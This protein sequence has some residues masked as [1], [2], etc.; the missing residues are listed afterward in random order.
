MNGREAAG[1]AVG[2][3]LR[4]ASV[5]LGG[6]PVLVW[7]AAGTE[8]MVLQ[9]V[10]TPDAAPTVDGDEVSAVLQQWH[11]PIRHGTRWVSCRL[12]DRSAWVIAPLRARPA[13]PP[14]HG[15][16]RRSRERM[17]LELAGLCLGL[18]DAASR[19]PGGD[20]LRELAGLP[21]MIA[22][23]A[24]NPLTAAR[25]GLQLAMSA[26]GGW[27]D[28][29]AE[30]RLELLADL[31]QVVADIDRAV[32][33]LRAVQDRARGAL[34]RSERFDAV[35]VVRSCITLESRV[36][37]DRGV[38]LDLDTSVESVYLKGDPN[39]LFDMLVNLI[40]NAADAY[41][42]R[43]GTVTVSLHQD[44]TVLRLA[45]RDQGIG[46]ASDHLD[47][48]FEAGF[49]TK[50]FGKGSGMG[51][52]LVRSVAEEMFAGRVTVT[53]EVGAGTTF[54]VSLPIPAQRGV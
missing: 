10:S 27:L 18:A 1:V 16:E 12:Q 51:L 3:I 46:I 41:P 49:T 4:Q 6:R 33:F 20:P 15:Q 2:E 5:A 39:A 45:V 35:R 22:H 14:P 19:A 37:R 54:T 36:L 31:G 7:E 26:V 34:A 50:E 24:S 21:A 32:S 30:R 47:R 9:A 11:V 44:H 38:R 29:A 48:V 25:A 42:T 52:A 53:S 43:A 17:V 28:L 8:Q 40:R 13:K 23:E